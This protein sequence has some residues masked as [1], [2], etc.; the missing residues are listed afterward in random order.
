MRHDLADIVRCSRIIGSKQKCP[1]ISSGVNSNGP[2]AS[3]SGI[4]TMDSM[5]PLPPADLL[6]HFGMVFTIEFPR[7]R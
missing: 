3:G 7:W 6:M 5:Y 1:L 2:V 4:F